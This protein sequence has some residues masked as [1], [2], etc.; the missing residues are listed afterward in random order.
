MN[1]LNPLYILLTF[2]VLASISF[3]LLSIKEDTFEK[4]SKNYNLFITKAKQFKSLRANNM[5]ENKTRNIINSIT[6][7][8]EYNKA[9]IRTHDNQQSIVID[10]ESEDIKLLDSFINKILNSKLS[11][12]KL[13]IQ[14]NK[15][16][17]EVG[18]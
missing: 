4:K 6:N 18:I 3:T 17:I 14:T 10:I 8:H 7:D 2:I 15:M 9:T 16:N 13:K 11:I 5:Q 12:S 1:R